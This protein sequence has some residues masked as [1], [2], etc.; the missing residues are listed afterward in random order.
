MDAVRT[1]MR[2]VGH[3]SDAVTAAKLDDGKESVMI[4]G[5]ATHYSYR[6]LKESQG[7]IEQYLEYWYAA[8]LDLHVREVFCTADIGKTTW[9]ISNLKM[10]EPDAASFRVPA[11]MTIQ[12]NAP[13]PPDKSQRENTPGIKVGHRSFLRLHR[14]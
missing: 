4:D 1:K 13:T 7:K 9:R 10:G 3:P 14:R 2:L 11:G 6:T 8:G 5:V 12:E